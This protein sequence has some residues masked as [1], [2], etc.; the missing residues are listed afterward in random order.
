MTVEHD[1][2]VLGT[3]CAGLVAALAALDA[4][5]DVGLYEKADSIGG[6]DGD[7][8]RRRLG[9][10]S[11]RTPRRPGIADSREDA[12][13]YLGSLSHGLIDMDRAGVLIDTGPEMLAFVEAVTPLRWRLVAGYPDYH[14]EHPGGKPEGGRS[15]EPEL[16]S[17]HELGEWAALVTDN[18]TPR[19]MRLAETPLGGGTRHRRPGRPGR[20][21]HR[22]TSGASARP[23]SAALL[24]GVL[25]KGCE[26]VI[27]ARAMDLL[28]EDGR[29][30]GRRASARR[31]RIR[32]ST[33]CG[34]GRGVVIAHGRLRVGRG[35]GARA[36]SAAR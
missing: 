14:P 9:R 21:A 30:V 1:V 16:Y 17:F 27:G 6:H 22:E 3:G 31:T 2:V 33:S 25:D 19:P 15:L 10:R 5:A 34:P 7:L 26:P 13:A 36:S 24:K 28:V 8:R 12:L 4:G 35:D 29:V 20:P 11:T 18:G 23:S 32:T